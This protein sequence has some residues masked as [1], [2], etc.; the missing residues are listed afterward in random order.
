MV[1]I[2]RDIAPGVHGIE[3]AHTNCYLVVDHTGVTMIDACFPSTWR[4][5]ERLLADLGLARGDVR[6]LVLTHGHFDHVGS[7]RTLQEDWEVPVWVHPG[8]RRLAAHPYR[9]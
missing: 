4:F 8:D 7:A 5:V 3:H 6:A 9:S 1:K 2:T